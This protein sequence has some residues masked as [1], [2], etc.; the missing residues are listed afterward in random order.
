MWLRLKVQLK[1][2]KFKYQQSTF[3]IYKDTKMESS[4]KFE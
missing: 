2:F 4:G 3:A 1:M